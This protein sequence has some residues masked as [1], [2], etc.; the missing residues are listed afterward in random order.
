MEI[1][2]AA[3]LRPNEWRHANTCN[4]TSRKPLQ[5]QLVQEDDVH[6]LPGQLLFNVLLAALD[7][8]VI[9]YVMLDVQ[10]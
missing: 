3:A 10:Q 9:L 1:L 7:E 5:S 2:Y 8:V 6:C 4:I